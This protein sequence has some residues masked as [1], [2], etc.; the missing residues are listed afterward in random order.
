MA[1]IHLADLLDRPIAFHRSF[2]QLTGSVTAALVLS[3]AVY[4]QR[5]VSEDHDGWWY[6]TRSQWIEETGLSRY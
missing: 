3:Q 1:D 6:K 2:V 4:W 5:R